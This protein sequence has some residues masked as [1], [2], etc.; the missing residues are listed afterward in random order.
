MKK[1]LLIL[2]LFC[3][4]IVFSQEKNFED[5][6]KKISN[7]IELITKTEKAA[8]KEKVEL[9]NKRLE[10]NEI[11]SEQ[12]QKLKR[13]AA[14]FHAKVISDKVAVEEKKLQLL[15]QDKAN[16]KIKSVQKETDFD[17]KE[18]SF[19]IGSKTYRIRVND[20]E[21]YDSR[22]NR[23]WR[24]RETRWKAKG[25]RNRSTTSQFVFAM[26]VNNVL[27]DDQLSTL[28]TSNYQLWQS[29]F[30]EIGF[31]WKTRFNKEAS[32]LYLKYG[33]SFLWNN[34]RLEDNKYHVVNGK[35]TDLVVHP[36]D[37]SENRLRHVQMNFPVHV[38]WDFSRNGEYND[39]YK[40]DRRN[41]SLRLGV[42][43]FTGFKLGTRQYIEYTDTN[44]TKVEELQKDN[45][46]MNIFNYGVS[47][48]IAY[49]STGFY[50]KYDL[51]P[52]FKNT[53]VRNLSMG[54]RFDFD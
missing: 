27:V 47:A 25:K 44:G 43:A 1:I 11:T 17:D 49:R 15:V 41:K 29:H 45:F 39:G 9:I 24:D 19:T 22:R 53:N 28:E 52:L 30:Y 7:R 40:R 54:I 26:G 6:V 2:V 50:V 42:G 46:N 13:E 10:R 3:T 12:A 31:T 18:N 21:D 33:L 20:N 5:E 38:E 8:L 23:R 16:G 48:Y 36:E 34:L 32:K 51:N 37:L 4:T 35:M 14:D